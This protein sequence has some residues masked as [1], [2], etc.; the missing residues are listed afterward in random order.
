MAHL[1]PE[2]V[3]AARKYAALGWPIAEIARRFKCSRST[4]DRVVKGQTHAR[5]QDPPADLR[6]LPA[7]P[8]TPQRPRRP[9]PPPVPTAT[10]DEL[11]LI[12]KTRGGA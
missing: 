7:P 10:L 2:Q 9:A 11:A 6:P 5:V 12:R 3:V 8:R 1:L 4:I